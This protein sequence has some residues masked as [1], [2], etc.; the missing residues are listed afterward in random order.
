MIR[1]A[2]KEDYEQ[3]IQL[4]KQVD[5]LHATNMPDFFVKLDRRGSQFIDNFINNN[6]AAMF[7]KVIGDEV[8]GL[9]NGFIKRTP[10]IPVF[11]KRKYLMVDTL[12][13]KK[14]WQKKGIGK[15]LLKALEEW[16]KEKNVH[17][18]EIN[19]WEFNQT[20]IQF[21][22]EKEYKVISRRMYKKI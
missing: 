3:L 1:F 11:K 7:V 5:D 21:Y 8:V 14:E 6:E 20:A 13:V 2:K 10:E 18:I 15:E 12:I 9:I 19:V 22:L 4:F 16:G 17:G